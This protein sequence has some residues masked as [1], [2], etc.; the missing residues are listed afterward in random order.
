ME[1][2]GGFWSG[3]FSTL[4]LFVVAFYGLKKLIEWVD[5]DHYK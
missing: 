3:V 4:V 2:W 1:Y 5:S